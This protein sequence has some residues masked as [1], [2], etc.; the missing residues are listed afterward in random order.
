MLQEYG[1]HAIGRAN[2]CAPNKVIQLHEPNHCGTYLTTHIEVSTCARRAMEPETRVWWCT[3]VVHLLYSAGVSMAAVAYII[4]T[5]AALD[6]AAPPA[7]TAVPDAIVCVSAG[8]CA[9]LL[10]ILVAYRCAAL[11]R[12]VCFVLLLPRHGID[13]DALA[14]VGS[15]SRL[16]DPL[17]SKPERTTQMFRRRFHAMCLSVSCRIYQRSY[18][19]ML[20]LTT[21]LVLFAAAAFKSDHTALLAAT[22]VSEAHTVFFLTRR[23]QVPHPE[24]C[25]S[26]RQH[27]SLWLLTGWLRWH[28]QHRSTIGRCSSVESVSCIGW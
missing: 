28:L 16:S 17:C 14:I 12:Y 21:L 6:V 10:W 20:H 24:R 3:D 15:N 4:T 5:P 26:H 9:F 2:V 1:H 19:K 27:D 11:I 13:N 18:L 25:G 23:L 22:L 8:F 7:L